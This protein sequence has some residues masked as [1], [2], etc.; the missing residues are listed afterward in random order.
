[1]QTAIHTR[2]RGASGGKN[3]LNLIIIFLNI[4][5][6]NL[7]QPPNSHGA[8]AYRGHREW[9]LTFTQVLSL[10]LSF[11]RSRSFSLSF[12]LSVSLSFSL[13]VSLS[14]SYLYIYTHALSL[15]LR[16]CEQ[17]VVYVVKYVIGRHYLYPSR[18]K[19]RSSEWWTAWVRTV[20]TSS[21]LPILMR[22][23]F[24]TYFHPSYLLFHK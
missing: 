4:I 14:L 6:Y 7:V 24:W 20:Q 11:S 15:L 21:I 8:S 1:M 17:V 3:S 18:P 5:F 19:K 13:S 22:T 2:R 9:R 12:F 16:R 10:C 23:K